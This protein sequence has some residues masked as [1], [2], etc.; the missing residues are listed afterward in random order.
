MPMLQR[1]ARS[2]CRHV[3]RG[4][5]ANSLVREDEGEHAPQLGQTRPVI[6]RLRARLE[7]RASGRLRVLGA[8]RRMVQS[9]AGM[10]RASSERA[11]SCAKRPRIGSK[12]ATRKKEGQPGG[13]GMKLAAVVVQVRRSRALAAWTTLQRNTLPVNPSVYGGPLTNRLPVGGRH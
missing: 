12:S 5:S 3:A 11:G 9:R 2:V 10:P 13:A 6:A 4:T 1:A 7:A 8:E